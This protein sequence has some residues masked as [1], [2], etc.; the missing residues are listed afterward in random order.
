M[1][2]C[3]RGHLPSGNR[4]H[5][6]PR[7][8]TVI[9]KLQ[10]SLCVLRSA[11]RR[12][13]DHLEDISSGSAVLSQIC[14]TTCL[15]TRPS[16]RVSL[17]FHVDHLLFAGTRQTVTEIVSELER[18]LEPKS[19]EGDDETNAL[20]VTNLGKNGG[21]ELWSRCVVRGRHARG[22]QHVHAQEHT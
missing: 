19:S 7:K 15:W 4:K 13:K 5:W 21:V 17:V 9:W 3:K 14:S 22:V 2:W 6:D 11:R 16:K 20:P 18:D 8:G 10:K 12:W 1:T